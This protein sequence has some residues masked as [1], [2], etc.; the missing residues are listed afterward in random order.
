MVAI[1]KD[2]LGAS[3]QANAALIFPLVVLIVGVK[4][5]AAA[6]GGRLLA[7]SFLVAVFLHQIPLELL[8]EW[9][10]YSIEFLEACSP[11]NVG[12]YRGILIN[13]YL[14]V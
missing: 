1:W 13:I 14:E 3:L 11:F 8:Q 10:Y 12:G 4:L 9:I 5:P 6:T 7:P 2:H